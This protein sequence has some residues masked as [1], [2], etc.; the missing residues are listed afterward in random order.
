MSL[1]PISAGID[2]GKTIIDKIW[3][4]AGESERRKIELILAEAQQQTDINKIEAAN[5]NVWVAGARPY[6]LWI[7]GTALLYCALVEPLMR[8]IAQVCFGYVGDFPS[9]DT[10]LTMQV[11]LGILGLGGFRTYE[12]VRG[13]SR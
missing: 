4:D 6:I 2:L 3:P 8:F 1:D 12:K 10:N 11:L 9:I 5:V 7:C 13:V